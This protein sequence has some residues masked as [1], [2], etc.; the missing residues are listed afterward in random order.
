MGPFSDPP[1]LPNATDTVRGTDVA[2]LS[3]HSDAKWQA[4]L[5]GVAG[6]SPYL[7]G[8]MRQNMGWLDE[9]AHAPEAA[10]RTIN[11][12]L[13][14][15]AATG[16]DLRQ[17]KARTA[18]ITG[19]AEIS[20]A[21][22][23]H[24]CTQALSDFAD[25]AVDAALRAALDQPRLKRKLPTP[26]R[27]VDFAGLTVL[28]MGK[29]GAGEL[30]YS[31]D[32][33]LIC[34]FDDTAYADAD[35]G[36]ARAGLIK[37]V[38]TAMALLSDVTEHGYVFRTDLRLRPDPSVTPVCLSISAAERYY[39]AL[40][41]TW[42]RAAFI[43]ARA[44]AG[45]L[46]AGR[47]FLRELTPFIWRKHLDFAAIQD[48]HELRL[49]IRDA[50]GLGG[51]IT[52]PG[53]NMKLG[54]GGIREIE[55][56]TQ[57]RQLIA[58]G[59]DP[60]LRLR[61]TCD[62]LAALAQ[63]GWIGQ[64][65][66]AELTEHYVFHRTIEHRLQMIN[67]AQTH[68]LP[69]TPEGF[70]R[71][72]DFLGR[73]VQGL[74]AELRSRLE[75]VHR[76]TEDFFAP[77]T[78]VAQASAGFGA[79]V[80]ANWHAYPAFR[81]DRASQIFDRLQPQILNGLQQSSDP[82]G[83]LRHFD[84]F[85]AGL[86]AGVQLFSLFQA[87]P[88]LIDLIVDICAISPNLAEYLSRNSRVLDAVL[89]GDFFD[90]WPLQADLM[91]QLKTAL[92]HEQDYEAVLDRARG[93][94]KERSF[95]VGVHHL[96]GLIDAAT[97][98]RQYS[99]LADVI[100]AGIAP[101]VT[102]QFAQ[103]HGAP[104]GKGVAVLA[105]GSLGARALNVASDLD[106]ITIYDA[107]GVEASQGPRPLDTRSYYARWTQALV[108]A[109]SAPMAQGRLY[110]VDMRLRPS[111]KQ[112]PVA[113]S[114]GGFEAYHLNEAWTWEHL[115]LTRARVIAG[116][117]SLAADIEAVRCVVLDQDRDRSATLADV[118][119]MTARLDAA[120]PEQG[121][122]DI[123]AGAGGLQQM[124]LVAQTMAVLSGSDACDFR[125]QIQSGVA[126]GMLKDAQSAALWSIYRFFW[127]LQATGRLIR[128]GVSEGPTN[129]DEL[130][131]S[132]QA[133]MLRETDQADGAALRAAVVNAKA[134]AAA[135][136]AAVMSNG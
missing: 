53:H 61:G 23:L 129:F 100:V 17:A 29:G 76:L 1:I 54:R 118:R 78:P 70:L 13:R 109:L 48:A 134:K 126:I 40:G 75:A 41:R 82:E 108:T 128:N 18:L 114:L 80:V 47:V 112:G 64:D 87:N 21:W 130:G 34:L 52:L 101:H 65:V 95:R 88:H 85:L 20:G 16:V 120:K 19:L 104:P 5:R 25:V 67:D 58:G 117:A 74:E 119:D 102:A 14:S 33:D 63:K 27:D 50:K 123:K 86:P 122:W 51:P 124:E 30:N 121:L 59:R 115:A 32:I 99:D 110:E 10:L 113:T 106:L 93:W 62:G 135:L 24:Q 42:E 69:T 111:G 22:P 31:S 12:A 4:L 84:M 45:N 81:S 8:V 96:R 35:V 79:D 89:G 46:E 7:A 15:G 66:A 91:G 97:A 2:G 90:P 125:Q 71:L 136:C 60:E 107:Q 38:Q 43:K 72:A 83:A 131:K 26:R 132:G 73:D 36:E 44:A 105:M 56:F 57:T 9:N 6:C 55:F 92:D 68:S 37:V 49:K 116:P 3:G 11:N 94:L 103:K 77:D 98:A 28:S 39:E 133:V 127:A